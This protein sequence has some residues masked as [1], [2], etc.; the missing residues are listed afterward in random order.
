MRQHVSITA[1]HR[2]SNR[3]LATSTVYHPSLVEQKQK[4]ML[5]SLS[6]VGTSEEDVRFDTNDANSAIAA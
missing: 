1:R 5:E 2:F 3:I 6:D 4:F